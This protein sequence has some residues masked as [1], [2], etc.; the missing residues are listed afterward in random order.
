MSKLITLVL[1]YTFHSSIEYIKLNL[2]IITN[3]F[4]L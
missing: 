4:Q 3:I 1:S 2:A